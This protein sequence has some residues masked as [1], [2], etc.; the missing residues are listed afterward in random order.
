MAH[1]QLIGKARAA[2]VAHIGRHTTP[3]IKFHGGG[4]TDQ[5]SNFDVPPGAGAKKES[6][7]TALVTAQSYSQ[8]YSKMAAAI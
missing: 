5:R 2:S 8:N 4:R 6:D 3:Q 7:K 1:A